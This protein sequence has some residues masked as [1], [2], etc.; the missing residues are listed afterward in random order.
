MGGG[1]SHG[2]MITIMVIY[3]LTIRASLAS[4][5][6]PSSTKTG[7]NPNRSMFMDLSKI[8]LRPLA[9]GEAI[10]STR[11]CWVLALEMQ[12]DRKYFMKIQCLMTYTGNAYLT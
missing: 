8:V 3:R 2:T 4:G 9:R 12:Q 1:L 7:I 5:A 10:A 6:I 11:S